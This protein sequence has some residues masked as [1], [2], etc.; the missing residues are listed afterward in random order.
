MARGPQ[1]V[2]YFGPVLDALRALG[3]SA[4]PREVAEWI[5]TE[6]E[7]PSEI[8]DGELK[9]G[10]SRFSN[11]VHWARF[12]LARAGLIDASKRGVWT[13]AAEGREVTLD[14]QQALDLFRKVHREFDTSVPGGDTPTIDGED[15]DEESGQ[16]DHRVEILRVLKSLPPE[17]FERLCQRLLRESGFENVTVTGRS[18]DGGIDGHGV[19]RLNPLVSFYVYFQCKRY[20]QPVGSPVVRDFRGA[21]VGRADKGII[22]TTAPFSSEARREAIRD[23]VP[24][25]ELVDGDDLIDMLESLELGLT[26]RTVYELDREFFAE[27]GYESPELGTSDEEDVSGGR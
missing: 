19:L 5:A 21:M 13:L 6:L 4:R 24:P 11:Q 3:G 12:Y 1:F 7:I 9:S 26:P 23:G 2:Q 14:H 27:Y 20:A 8:L 16:Q 10:G 22:L 18:G 17:G 15:L 25:I